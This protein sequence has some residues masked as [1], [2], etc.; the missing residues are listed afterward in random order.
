MSTGAKILAVCVKYSLST[1]INLFILGGLLIKRLIV[2]KDFFHVK[3]R[4]VPPSIL[5]DKKWGMHSYMSLKTQGI[6]LHYVEAGDRQNPLIVCVHGFPECWFSWRHQLQELSQNYWVVAVDMRG[7][8]DSDKPSKLSDY[9]TNTL[10]EDLRQFVLALGKDKCILMAHD[11]GAALAWRLV[12]QYPELFS[13]HINLNGPHPSVFAKHLQ[14][15]WRQKLMSWY[16]LFFQFPWIPELAIS[17]QDL[18]MFEDMF[19]G[20]KK[21]DEDYD[22]V[23]EGFKYYFSQKG[24][25]TPPLNYYRNIDFASIAEKIPKVKVPTLIIWG[26]NDIA[27]SKDLAI[28]AV[29]ECETAELKF[30]EDATHFVQQDKPQEVNAYILDYLSHRN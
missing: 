20:M 8:A 21:N 26:V 27:L 24:A 19:K 18:K 28:K 10:T 29:D 3:P 22:A 13:A 9:K 23:I 7:Y 15:S 14:S 4:P 1:I 12:I 6:K 25:L 5:T 2:G 11:W 16:M 30:V 17:V